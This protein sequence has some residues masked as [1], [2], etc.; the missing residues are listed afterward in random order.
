MLAVFLVTSNMGNQ[1]FNDTPNQEIAQVHAILQSGDY[2]LLE[3][4]LDF[5][6]WAE[7]SEEAI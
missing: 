1:G 3:N 7:E 5:Y 6:A 2:E 4:D